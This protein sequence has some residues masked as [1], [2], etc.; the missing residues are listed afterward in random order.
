MSSEN[1]SNPDGRIYWQTPEGQP[2]TPPGQAGQPESQ[3]PS[4]PVP[5]QP[6]SQPAAPVQGQPSEPVPG[7]PY[8]QPSVP[9]QGQPHPQP[10]VPVSG[11]PY[12]QPSAP[13]QGQPYSQPSMPVQGQPY[14]QPYPGQP[15][16]QQPFQ[17]QP[18]PGQPFQQQPFPGQ[19]YQQQ[20]FP[21]QPF[22]QQPFPGQ[23]YPGQPQQGSRKR[24]YALIACAVF[25]V[26]ALAVGS[27]VWL[28]G[29]E[30][31]GNKQAFDK[32][33]ADVSGSPGLHYVTASRDGTAKWDV[34]V[35]AAGDTFGT[36]T[37]SSGETRVLRVDKTVY[38]D[39]PDEAD[40]PAS[41]GKW[42]AGS[43][44]FEDEL[45]GFMSPKEFADALTKAVEAALDSGA[46][47]TET[48]VDGTPALELKTEDG[49]LFVTTDEPHRVLR[50]DPDYLTSNSAWAVLDAM[51]FTTITTDRVDWMYIQLRDRVNQLVGA[52]DAGLRITANGQGSV[53]CSE[54][55]C[56]ITQ[57]F[58]GAV[59]GSGNRTQAVATLS[60]TFTVEGRFAGTCSSSGTFPITAA[61]FSGSL[62]CT[63]PEAGGVFGSVRAGQQADAD[64]RAQAERRDIQFQTSYA[65]D[66]DIYAEAV[67]QAEVT[68]LL[69]Q[70][71]KNRPR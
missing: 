61:S 16:P 5:G 33:I 50:W 56:T 28:T 35:S 36:V 9:I 48:T 46:E 11:Q 68:R 18:F 6:P 62:S 64:R 47:A 63:S 32:A 2:G 51:D 58:N 45:P 4:G 10:S 44:Q 13:I 59:S 25:V 71:E 52:V 41:K 40:Q 19:Q 39:P 34:T 42:Q 17:Q 60:A 49:T 8:S 12:S 21:G 57:A 66:Y 67:S 30:S 38:L 37:D 7:Q 54:G 22:Q 29:S 26:L 3:Q 69:D 70:L 14:Q 31:S 23:P 65:A 53:N 15:Y 27:A 43:T 1:E 55:G 20:P 24:V